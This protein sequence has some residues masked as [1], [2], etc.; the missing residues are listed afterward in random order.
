[1]LVTRAE[2]ME[3]SYH[4]VIDEAGGEAD[5]RIRLSARHP[6]QQTSLLI[7]VLHRV[8][9]EQSL[10]CCIQYRLMQQQIGYIGAR[11]EHPLH[12]GQAAVLTQAEE[13]LDLDVDPADGLDLAELVDRAGDGEALLERYL[14][15]GGDQCADLAQRGAVTVDIAVGLLKGDARGDLQLMILRVAAAQIAGEDHHPL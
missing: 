9:M 3:S 13:A 11:N 10:A 8:D 14:G 15:Q 2:V 1:M 5:D 4:P 7:D 12:P 6:G